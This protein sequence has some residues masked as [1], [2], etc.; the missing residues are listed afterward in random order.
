MAATGEVFR[1]TL[2][3]SAP[4]ASSIQNVFWFEYNGSSTANSNVFDA[5]D[6]W[7]NN[8]WGV[9]WQDLAVSDF[10][11]VQ[12]HVQRINLDGT[13]QGEL[14]TFQINLNGVGAG[15][16]NTGVVNAYMQAY[17]ATPG[18]FGRKYVP[19][20]GDTEI[21][22]G[23]LNVETLADLAVLL[24]LWVSAI[25]VGAAGSLDPGVLSRTLGTFL[26]FN[27]TGLLTDVPAY[28]RRRKPNVGV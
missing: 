9:Q 17:T 16:L 24:A 6:D 5:L 4:N 15:D 25:D 2:E 11:L 18:H 28:Q 22:D 3:Y 21:V 8:D 27:D 19:G 1:L 12:G 7:A 20:P 26:L 23:L 10:E 13:V 14:G